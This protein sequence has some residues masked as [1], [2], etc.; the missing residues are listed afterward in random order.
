[1]K[2]KKTASTFLMLNGDIGQAAQEP[3]DLG[4]QLS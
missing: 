3:A 2:H 4:E 1:M